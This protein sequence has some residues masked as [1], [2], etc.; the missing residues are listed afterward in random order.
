MDLS[1]YKDEA[2]LEKISPSKRKRGAKDKNDDDDEDYEVAPSKKRNVT[3]AAKS[4]R[5][6]A[7]NKS[8]TNEDS[9]ES[10]EENLME[11]KNKAKKLV[12]LLFSDLIG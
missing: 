8:V 7:A 11:I 5:A 12:S 4:P 2:Q 1:L 10:D 6:M 9:T 3:A